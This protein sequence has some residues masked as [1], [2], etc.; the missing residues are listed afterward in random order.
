MYTVLY[1][2]RPDCATKNINHCY[3]EFLYGS[4]KKFMLFLNE[5]NGFHI[6][7]KKSTFSIIYVTIVYYYK[8]MLSCV[9]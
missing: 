9:N 4:R 7:T 3:R 5:K 8:A 2:N 6:L 1:T